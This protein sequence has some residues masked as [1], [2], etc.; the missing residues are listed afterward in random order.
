MMEKVKNNESLQEKMKELFHFGFFLVNLFLY[1]FHCLKF[2][3][4]LLDVP[5]SQ[6]M[7]QN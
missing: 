7:I 5:G 4:P 3:P 2:C 6:S 1:F